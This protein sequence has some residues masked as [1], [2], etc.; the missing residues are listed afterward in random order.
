MSDE[1]LDRQTGLGT[2]NIRSLRMAVAESP[3]EGSRNK[4]EDFPDL[5]NAVLGGRE[6]ATKVL[7]EVNDLLLRQMGSLGAADAGPL[8]AGD[9][10][11]QVHKRAQADAP[12]L[13]HGPQWRPR[14]SD[15]RMWASPSRGWT[16]DRT[17]YMNP[18]RL[19]KPLPHPRHPATARAHR[20][21][22]YPGHHSPC[23]DD[24]HR[25]ERAGPR[26]GARDATR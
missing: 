1:Y 9:A 16:T 6:A 26:R 13:H 4:V 14:S 2:G 5:F 21:A 11:P 25:A 23:Q 3:V 12:R 24:Y 22:L 10:L 20:A 8:D 18:F 15:L 7:N 17:I 19:T